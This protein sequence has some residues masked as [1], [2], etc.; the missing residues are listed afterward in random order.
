ME[1]VNCK[2]CGKEI[3]QYK[4]IKRKHCSLK[5]RDYKSPKERFYEK[6]KVN[7]T[8]LCW[9]WVASFLKDGYG[10]FNYRPYAQSAHRASWIIH[11]GIIP[12]GMFVCHKCDNTKCVNPDHLFLGTP[13]DNNRDMIS[14]GREIYPVG[15]ECKNAILTEKDVVDIRNRY[16]AGG[17]TQRKLAKEYKV[18][19]KAISKIIKRQRWKHV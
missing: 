18:G 8:T 6:F 17:I 12:N 11:K 9:N 1:I 14:K 15:S 5:C 7:E 2:T 3:K 4:S 13:L 10:C 16:F 19:Y